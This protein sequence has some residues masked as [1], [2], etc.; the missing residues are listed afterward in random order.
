MLPTIQP[1]AAMDLKAQFPVLNNYTYLNTAY[2]GILS[3]TLQQWRSKH[4]QDFLK[5][6]SEFRSKQ[7]SLIPETK[8]N[9]ARLFHAKAD[10]TF[11]VPNFSVGFNTFLNGLNGTQRFLLL[12]EDYPSVNYPV[13]SRGHECE[14]I[15]ADQ[16]LEENLTAKIKT[17]N[18][19]VL[20]LSLVQYISGIKID[21]D[22]LKRIKSLHPELIIVADATQF[23]GTAEFNF[24]TSG[25]DVLISSGYKWMMSGFGNGFVFIKDEV[26][27]L[28]YHQAQIASLPTE[29]FLQGRTALSLYF[30]PGHQDTLAF[31]SL[32]QSV[33]YL[34]NAGLNMIE[35]QIKQLSDKAKAAFTVR[36]LLTEAV[37]QRK[38]HSSIFNLS[39]PLKTAEKLQEANILFS[40]RGKGSRVSFHFYNTEDELNHLLDIIDSCY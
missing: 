19:T 30:E 2:S 36:G 28:L 39:I 20:A 7:L 10:K 12:Q 25:L 16:Y 15:I 40:P 38:E 37:T 11:L 33:L 17:F 23:C 21:F 32:N 13:Q 1:T 29:P 35:S 22:L 27:P 18:P 31:G 4:E 3:K 34:E 26:K 24:E 6:G 5:N 9:L 8:Q 14:Y